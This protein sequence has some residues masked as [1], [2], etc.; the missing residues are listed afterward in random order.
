MIAAYLLEVHD[1]DLEW[2]V[3]RFQVKG[4]CRSASRP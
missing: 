1:D 4:D 2:D 3:D